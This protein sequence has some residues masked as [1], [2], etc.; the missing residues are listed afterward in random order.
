VA[1]S[2][3]RETESMRAPI[4]DVSPPPALDPPPI[5][6]ATPVVMITTFTYFCNGYR[7]PNMVPKIITGTG[8]QDLKR[9]C[10]GKMTYLKLLTEVYV[11]MVQ[12]KQEGKKRKKKENVRKKYFDKCKYISLE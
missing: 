5:N 11:L 2:K 9:T 3:Q 12:K 4:S 7:F 6:R 8:L 10:T 1:P